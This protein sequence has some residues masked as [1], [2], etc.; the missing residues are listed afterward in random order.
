MME[1]ELINLTYNKSNLSI[2]LSVNLLLLLA[3][4]LLLVIIIFLARLLRTKRMTKTRFEPVELNI[5]I[6]GVGMKYQIVK[7]YT[8]IEIAHKI[9]IELITRKAAIPYD[10]EDDLICD[11][12]DSWYNLFQIT[13][14]EIKNLNGVLLGKNA[15]SNDLVELTTDILNK[16]LRP[17]LTKYQASFRKWFI[18]ENNKRKNESPQII[19]KDYNDYANLI[20]SLKEVNSLLVLYAIK[21][22]ELIDS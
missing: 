7:N 18:E 3:V 19:Q 4:V 1:N 14:N 8:N 20:K 17:H 21:L 13:R 15:A 22:K 12:Y 2:E 16:G 9:Y 11:I 6:G 10:E 5:D